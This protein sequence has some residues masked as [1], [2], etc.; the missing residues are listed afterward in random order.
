M[1]EAL[2]QVRRFRGV[3]QIF[4]FNWH[5]YAVT[6]VVD[7][8]AMFLTRSP[9]QSGLR[10]ALCLIAVAATFWAL[11][12]L[13]VSHY[14]YD[15]SPLYKWDWLAAVLKKAPENWVNIHAGLDETSASLIRLFPNARRRIL[16][17]FLASEMSEPSIER[18]RRL[19]QNPIA[20]ERASPF[21]LPL[22]D[23][24]S[25]AFFLIL[26]AHELR[27]HASRVRLF[28]EIRRA[29]RQGGCI[30][31][32]EHLR[33]WR[34]FLAFGP[35]FL[36]FFSRREWL[37]VAEQA[38]LRITTESNV[39]PFIGCFV[40]KKLAPAGQHNGFERKALHDS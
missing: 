34:N 9:M 14:I 2:Q 15:R 37:S 28:G 16:D 25:D 38:G 21:D 17:I 31:L 6:F 22:E 36:H 40:F 26:A 5:F 29:L 39:T 18:A 27:D 11:A 35:G 12:S 13:L 23:D 4:V 24:E 19:A 33:D 8:A 1:T 32:V 7:C 20:P 30:V 3:G 10:F